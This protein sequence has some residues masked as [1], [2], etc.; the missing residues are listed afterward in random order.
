MSGSRVTGRAIPQA[1]HPI[2]RWTTCT[3]AVGS[4]ALL[5]HREY[6]LPPVCRPPCSASASPPRRILIAVPRSPLGSNRRLNR[7][8]VLFVNRPGPDRR[9]NPLQRLC[10]SH[11]RR[12]L[13]LVTGPPGP[14]FGLALRMVLRYVVQMR[15]PRTPRI[16]IQSTPNCGR[17]L[18]HEIP[19]GCC[20]SDTPT[21]REDKLCQRACPSVLYR[22]LCCADDHCTDAGNLCEPQ[23]H[24]RP[25]P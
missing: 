2:P 21:T 10:E 1:K 4:I 19:S 7:R 22:R 17:S 12:Q 20:L 25:H 23:V 18:R 9:L 16:S 14:V 15:S 24:S 5:Y 6:M 11:H 3:A 13:R 8:N